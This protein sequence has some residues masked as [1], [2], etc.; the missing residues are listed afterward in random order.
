MPLTDTKILSQSRN[1]IRAR[2]VQQFRDRELGPD[3]RLFYGPKQQSTRKPNG[4]TKLHSN[5]SAS[6][7]LQNIDYP[8]GF[9]LGNQSVQAHFP[10][11]KWVGFCCCFIQS[12]CS[13][14]RQHGL[15][16]T[17]EES[18][19]SRGIV[20]GATPYFNTPL[21]MKLLLVDC[22]LSIRGSSVCTTFH[23]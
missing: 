5:Y 2:I 11:R 23:C 1:R 15:D 20:I 18:R 21:K 10:S 3:S 8:V 22:I 16:L 14:L 7:Q 4:A 9:T 13:S 17:K 6:N 12:V 19:I